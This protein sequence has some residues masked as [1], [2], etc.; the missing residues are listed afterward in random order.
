LDLVHE[1]TAT[2]KKLLASLD[3]THRV[4]AVFG[5]LVDAVGEK[6][7]GRTPGLAC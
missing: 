3:I 7:K 5:N 2:T 4:F 6:D 1:P